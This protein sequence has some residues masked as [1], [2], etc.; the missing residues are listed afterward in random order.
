M[1]VRLLLMVLFSWFLS[2]PVN[3]WWIEKLLIF[4]YW[5]VF[6]YIAES[7]YQVY[8]FF[9]EHCRS[10][11]YRIIFLNKDSLTFHV[12]ISFISFSCLIALVGILVLYQITVGRVNTFVLFMTLEEIIS[13]FPH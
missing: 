9:G 4:M 7:V 11:K 1:H 5:F 2:L 6:Y 12:W 8:E 3:C 13:V 10:V